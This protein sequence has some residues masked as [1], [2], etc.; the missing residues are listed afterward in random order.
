[1]DKA[2]LVGITDYPG[3]PLRGCLHD[4]KDMA[5]LLVSNYKFRMSAIRLLTDARATTKAII[6]RLQ[7]LCS[8]LHA[9]DRILFHYSGHGAQMATRN[10]SGEPDGLDEV[11]C[12]SDFDWSDERAIRDK[13]FAEIFSSIPDG[14]EA[15][16]ISDSCHSGDL[17]RV[18]P[19]ADCVAR[20]YPV[21]PDDIE[22]RRRAAMEDAVPRNRF[23]DIKDPRIALVSACSDHETA[24]DAVFNGRPNGALTYHLIKALRE[25]SGCSLRETMQLVCDC[26]QGQTPELSG[27]DEILTRP[28]LSIPQKQGE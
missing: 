10:A 17:C 15:V 21:V 13:H 8:D 14:V 27:P 26:V 6:E 1:M 20:R 2:L 12:P 25:N 3:A 19:P 11:I 18:I 23:R 22:W 7:W 5:E 9:G 16:W 4:V 28:F 24:A